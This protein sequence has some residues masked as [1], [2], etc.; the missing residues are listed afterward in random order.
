M[1]TIAYRILKFE[2][3][4]KILIVTNDAF[5]TFITFSKTISFGYIKSF[6]MQHLYN[7]NFKRIFIII[8]LI[9]IYYFLV[10][11]FIGKVV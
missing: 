7:P 4:I 6:V 2:S 11:K 8:Y 10:C 9:L 5:F 1:A 3:M